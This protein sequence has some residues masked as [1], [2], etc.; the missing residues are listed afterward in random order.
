MAQRHTKVDAYRIL[1][2]LN[3]QAAR[4]GLGCAGHLAIET[5]GGT[6]LYLTD[7]SRMVNGRNGPGAKVLDLAKGWHGA[8]ERLFT[9][10]EDLRVVELDR[11]NR[12]A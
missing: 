9:L 4:L 5:M 12:E 10:A 2:R 1:G 6:Y 7:R 8:Y 11:M 3:D